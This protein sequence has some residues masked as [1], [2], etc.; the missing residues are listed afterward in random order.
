M[1]LKY[2]QSPNVPPSIRMGLPRPNIS[3]IQN[4]AKSIEHQSTLGP[5]KHPDYI[6]DY[7]LVPSG[8]VSLTERSAVITIQARITN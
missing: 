6:D 7:L 5:L 8:K 3:W 4:T 2:L 1:N